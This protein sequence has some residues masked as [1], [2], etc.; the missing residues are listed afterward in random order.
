MKIITT[1]GNFKFIDGSTAEWV[2]DPK[3][4]FERPEIRYNLFDKLLQRLFLKKEHRKSIYKPIAKELDFSLN[5]YVMGS[6]PVPKS[7]TDYAE[8]AKFNYQNDVLEMVEHYDKLHLNSS[9]ISPKPSDFKQ[10]NNEDE[11]YDNI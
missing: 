9:E 2:P 11:N 7:G 4:S 8:K 10:K 3:G 1:R 5:K 6:D